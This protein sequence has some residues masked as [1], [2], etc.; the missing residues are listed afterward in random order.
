[1]SQE[2]VELVR[3][4]YEDFAARGLEVAADYLDQD[5]E[6]LPPKD[7]PHPELYRGVEGARAELAEWS[8]Q[9][10]DY[11]WEPREFIAASEGRVVVIGQQRG[12]GKVSGADVT[13]EETH[14][15]ALRDGKAVRLEMFASA[16]DA[17]EAVGLRE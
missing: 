12:R 4:M 1:M 15:W 8:G 2:N 6:W 14:V 13:A 5:I 9:F 10:H 17:L 3:R 7:A 16:K 11:A